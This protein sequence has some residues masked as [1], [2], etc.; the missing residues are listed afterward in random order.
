[1]REFLIYIVIPF[2]VSY[3]FSRDVRRHYPGQNRHLVSL[4]ATIILTLG[5][6]FIQRW[7]DR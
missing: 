3:N 4:I 7:I 6:F 1:M 2:F 5:I